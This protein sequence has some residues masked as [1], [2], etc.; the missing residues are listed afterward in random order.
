MTKPPNEASQHY[1]DAVDAVSEAIADWFD[2]HP[3][4]D[5]Q[6]RFPPERVVVT[7]DLS[8]GPSYWLPNPDGV[9][10]VAYVEQRTTKLGASM[11][12]FQVCFEFYKQR[13]R[14]RPKR[15]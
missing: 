13:G 8:M 3:G 6:F 11:L 2:V 9:D 4:A 7:G 12:Q 15:N 10:L 14:A 1:S 5:P